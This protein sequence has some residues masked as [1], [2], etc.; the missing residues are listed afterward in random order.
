MMKV[1]FFS[2]GNLKAALQKMDTQ[3]LEQAQAFGLNGCHGP[4]RFQSNPERTWKTNFQFYTHLSLNSFIYFCKIA[5]LYQKTSHVD[6]LATWDMNAGLPGTIEGFKDH[7]PALSWR[8]AGG[9]VKLSRTS[10][11][12]LTTEMV[13]FWNNVPFPLWVEEGYV[14]LHYCIQNTRGRKEKKESK[15]IH[16]VYAWKITPCC[17]FPRNTA[18]SICFSLL[19]WEWH[20]GDPVMSRILLCW[21]W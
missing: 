18:T 1:S 10:E 21:M 16:L 2:N 20:S 12:A 8:R 3:Y 15:N 14:D 17:L 11:T 9:I 6:P 5:S 19:G 7:L 4:F 13:N